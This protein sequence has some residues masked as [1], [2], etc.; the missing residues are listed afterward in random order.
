V[1]KKK[2][3]WLRNS[4]IWQSHANACCGECLPHVT[5]HMICLITFAEPKYQNQ[6][7]Q[8]S[9]LRVVEQPHVAA[10]HNRLVVALITLGYIFRW[11][12][13]A[14]VLPD[15]EPDC[16]STFRHD[17]R[18]RTCFA[19]TRV[20]P[21]LFCSSLSWH[22]TCTCRIRKLCRVL[23]CGHSTRRP[24]PKAPPPLAPGAHC[25]LARSDRH[26]RLRDDRFTDLCRSRLSINGPSTS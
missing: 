23:P 10:Y 11:L 15:Y 16:T 1:L 4:I 2:S 26:T 8:S 6:S 12:A 14:F 17:R 25:L 20:S 5:C 19:R 18:Q 21:C 13:G 9:S 22:K 7:T 3:Y 24:V